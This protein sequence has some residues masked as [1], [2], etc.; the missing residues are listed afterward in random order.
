[1]K[2]TKLL[3]LLFF[4]S[5]NFISAQ[6]YLGIRNSNYAGIQSAGLNPSSLADSKLKRDINVF[7][8]NTVYD[9]TFLF[10]PRDSL[11]IFG[12]KNIITDI[13]N[14]TQFFTHFDI[15]HPDRLYNVT[16]SNELLGPSFMMSV[17]EKSAIGLTTGARFYANIN[18]ITGHFGQNAFVYLQ[19]QDLWNKTFRDNTAKLNAMGWLEY[20]LTYATV[21]Y[22]KRKSELKAGVTLKYLQGIAAGYFNNMNITYNLI[23]TSQIT[24]TNS[25]INYGRTD[26]NSLIGS[27]GFGDL[28]HGHGFGTNIGF[29]YVHFKNEQMENNKAVEDDKNYLY[30]IGISLIDA[31]TINFNKNT[32]AFHLPAD[33]AIFANWKAT[34]VANNIQFDKIM[35]AVFYNNDSTKSL[36]ST[37]FYMPLPLALSLQADYNFC[38]NFF[39]NATIVKGFKHGSRQGVIR[40]DVYSLTPRYETKRFEIS[41]PMSLLYYGYWQPRLGLAARYGCFFIGGDALGGLLKINDF[42]GTDF[43]AGVHFFVTKKP[44]TPSKLSE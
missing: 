25:S 39:V 10:I 6:Q 4:C 5:A 11:H 1:M 18:N 21:V 20:G 38:K 33:T 37:R 7:S 29:T 2:R 42:E 28:I 32:G 26:Y 31:G 19:E 34:H 27:K 24:F 36:T 3:L 13:I 12:F 23:G 14:Q 41:V 35:S 30:R 15:Q 40:P 44:K 22:A 8:T 43:Y 17:G 9:N 16:F